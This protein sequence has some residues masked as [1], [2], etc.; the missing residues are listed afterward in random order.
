MYCQYCLKEHEGKCLKKVKGCAKLIR[1]KKGSFK[2]I[3]KIEE[4]D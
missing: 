4:V 2:A 1:T 3:E